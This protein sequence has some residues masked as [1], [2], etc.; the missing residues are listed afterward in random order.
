MFLH[1]YVDSDLSDMI[2]MM[3][4]AHGINMQLTHAVVDTLYVGYEL[5][6]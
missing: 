6:I 3:S 5:W 1:G 4:V 2:I